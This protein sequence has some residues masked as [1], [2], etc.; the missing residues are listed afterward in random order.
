MELFAGALLFA[1][2]LLVGL[3]V[4]RPQPP[5]PDNATPILDRI[6]ERLRQM[7]LVQAQ[8]APPAA[9]FERLDTR[10]REIEQSRA[11]AQGAL[12]TNLRTLLTQTASLTQALKAP[13]VRGRWGE[14][15]LKRVVEIAGMVNY[16]DFT[17][18]E[19]LRGEDG[20]FRPDMIIRLPNDRTIVVD[21]KTPLK[22]YLEGLE[23]GDE[24]ARAAAQAQHAQQLR[25]HVTKLAEKSYWRQFE[26]RTPEFVVCFLPGENFFSAALEHDPELIE[27]GAANRVVIATPTT[28]IA[29]LKAVA[30]GWNQEKVAQSAQEVSAAGRLLYERLATFAEHLAKTGASLAAAVGS[31]NQAIGSFESRVVPQARRFEE[32]GAAGPKSVLN[33]PPI[34]QNPRD[35]RQS[36]LPFEV[37]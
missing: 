25:T 27:F 19:T 10:L 24:T 34:T 31:Y 9:Q 12:E 2:G 18:Q 7:E 22:A 13:H 8:A 17:E 37:E 1:A 11:Q 6:D 33:P 29:L 20:R 23:A 32:L 4:R 15:Q 30:H 28:L 21:S 26:S 16:V 36:G 3:W 14:V 5:P 35:I